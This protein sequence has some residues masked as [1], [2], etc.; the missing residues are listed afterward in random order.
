[1]DDLEGKHKLY[2]IWVYL[3]NNRQNY[4]E[5]QIEFLAWNDAI[6]IIRQKWFNYG[7]T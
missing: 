3:W 1:M 7:K 6:D 5:T 2:R 4:R